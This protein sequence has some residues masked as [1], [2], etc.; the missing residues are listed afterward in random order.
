MAEL[1]TQD[2]TNIQ[3]ASVGAELFNDSL[4]A[5]PLLKTLTKRKVIAGTTFKGLRRSDSIP[6]G[7]RTIGTGVARNGSTYVPVSVDLA[8][9][10]NPIAIDEAFV[11][12]V[13]GTQAV[14]DI[15]VEESKSASEGVLQSADQAAFN[16]V[17]NGPASLVALADHEMVTSATPEEDSDSA[18]NSIAV[19]VKEPEVEVLFGADDVMTMGEWGSQQ[20]T[21]DNKVFTAKTNDLTMWLAYNP[22]SKYSIAVL[23][24]I[25]DEN[26]FTDAEVAKVVSECKGQPYTHIFVSRKSV[27]QLQQSRKTDLMP[28]PAWPTE[29]MGIAL[30]ISDNIANDGAFVDVSAESTD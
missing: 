20:V 28:S 18:E 14:E 11:K 6:G 12:S 27:Y 19:F 30:V 23:A 22:K 26:P 5:S 2:S 24:N 25:S 21:V 7:W 1:V 29:S 4:N 10:S 16:T 13:K 17:S 8:L 3:S 15:L 9:Y